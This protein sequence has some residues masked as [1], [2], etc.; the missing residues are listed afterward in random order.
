MI[1]HAELLV[2]EKLLSKLLYESESKHSRDY[3]VCIGEISEICRI[4]EQDRPVLNNGLFVP[5]KPSWF[6]KVGTHSS[7][8]FPVINCNAGKKDVLVDVDVA[9]CNYC[10]LKNGSGE[11]V[12]ISELSIVTHSD[13]IAERFLT[14][15][16]VNSFKLGIL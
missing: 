8:E 13:K 11:K 7:F 14:P 9:D 16:I 10:Y 1:H 4:L 15:V 2:F 12:P 3:S 6:P 5:V